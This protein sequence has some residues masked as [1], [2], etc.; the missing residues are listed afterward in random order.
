LFAGI[1]RD[2]REGD[3]LFVPGILSGERCCRLKRLPESGVEKPAG[4]S[5]D[6]TTERDE[7][8][9]VAPSVHPH[10][11]PFRRLSRR[12][13]QKIPGLIAQYLPMGAITLKGNLLQFLTIYAFEGEV[14]PPLD[15]L[16]GTYRW[17][18]FVVSFTG[19]F[20]SPPMTELTAVSQSIEGVGCCH[21][22]N[23]PE[24]YWLIA[25]GI[26][27]PDTYVYRGFSL[28]FGIGRSLPHSLRV[29][30]L[31]SFTMGSSGGR[32]AGYMTRPTG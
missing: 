26:S 12:S 11:Q 22:F 20:V 25:R 9:V 2:T 6:R 13:R 18:T 23:F 7:E 29:L 5:K 28:V 14:S 10:L 16:C 15:P 27:R 32:L 19:G 1:S 24:T 4:V 8:I 3:R 21:C 17:L 30:S 31:I